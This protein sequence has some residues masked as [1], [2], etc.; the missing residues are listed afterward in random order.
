[1]C[2]GFNRGFARARGDIIVFSHDDIEILSPNFAT[3][4]VSALRTHDVIGIAGSCAFPES[5]LWAPRGSAHAHG[6][7]AH[8]IPGEST[9][10]S[11]V[12]GIGAAVTPCIQV[13]DGVFFAARREVVEKLRFDAETFDGFHFYDI[14]FT[15][16]AA[17][18][19]FH[20][21]VC[22]EICV[23]HHSRGS[24]GPEWRM[25]ADRFLAKHQRRLENPEPP[26]RYWGHAIVHLQTASQV[27][28]LLSALVFIAQQAAM[29]STPFCWPGGT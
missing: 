17:L 15:Y 8:R 28:G 12:F 21:A 10:A 4:L 6:Q 20:V 3:T 26:P 22:N 25:Y 24:F 2:E 18:S 7:V 9:Y 16:R 19:G 29:E 11:Y 13:L 23:V 5:G 14:D 1:L 27:V